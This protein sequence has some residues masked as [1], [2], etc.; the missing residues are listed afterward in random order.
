MRVLA[1]L[2]FALAFAAPMAAG[3]P[4]ADGAAVF[5]TRCAACHRA[6]SETR[7]PL[8]AVLKQLSRE[9][10]I[11]ALTTGSM[12]EQGSQLTDEERA[13]VVTF[14][15]SSLDATADTANTCPAPMPKLSKFAGWQGWSPSPG[16]T[17][18][19][20]ITL[21]PTKLKLAWAF[22][23][24]GSANANGQPA[25]VDGVVFV[26]GEKGILTALDSRTGCEHWRF[27]S[28][29]TVRTSVLFHR[30]LALFA[31]TKTNVYAID[32]QTGKQV[33][34]VKL[35]PHPFARITGTPALHEG[36]L[37]VPIS[38]AE[39]VPAGNPKYPC[40]TFRGSVVAL[41]PA[42]GRQLWQHFLIPEVPQP[43]TKSSAGTQ[44]YGPAGAAIWL[45]PTI[46]PARK[47]LYIGTGNSYT[48]PPSPYSDAI[49]A[50]DLA[51]GERKWH[52]QLTPNDRWN[53]GC[54]SPFKANC[55]PEAGEDY[56]FGA[57]PLLVG[58]LLIAGQKSGIVHAL[59]PDQAGKIVWQTR[60]GKGGALGGV[61][62]GIGA[63][64]RAV[65][66]PVSDFNGR[67]PT[68]GGGLYALQIG[69]GEKLWHTPA[70]ELTCKGTP[71]CNAAQMAPPTILQNIVFSGSMDGHLRAYDSKSGAIIW[72]F[73]T[74]KPFDTVNRV[75]AKGGSLNSTGPVIVGT[76]GPGTMLF[77]QSGYGSLGGMPGNVLLAF[78]VE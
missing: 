9:A 4:P 71:A 30:S 42:D 35:D 68:A 70:P 18:Y 47:L 73:D 28:E 38:S 41:D 31:D 53:L 14:A 52:Q 62:F 67:N 50:L 65:Y 76:G 27:A 66:V 12:K 20:P 21:D 59:D 32:A 17:R 1:I 45:T 75:P 8:P 57:S 29:A 77:V 15:A 33:W 34:K 63:D 23:H 61:E 51:T 43:T 46:D 10:M 5:A 60:V 69:T 48:D 22:G 56:D 40:C 19:L 36:R 72:D 24:A 64:A 26:G 6:G 78:R 74:L 54:V 44:L 58:K 55:P 7:A 2:V 3:A 25:V 49:V 16:N 39:E 37:Y 11:K 13:A